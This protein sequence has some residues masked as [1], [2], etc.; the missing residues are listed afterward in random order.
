MQP[1]GVYQYGTSNVVSLKQ[2]E[3]LSV[4]IHPEANMEKQQHAATSTTE[5]TTTTTNKN[6]ASI[7][8][9]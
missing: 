4:I 5:T 6:H 2:S 7:F 9:F 8:Y 1:Q 3:A